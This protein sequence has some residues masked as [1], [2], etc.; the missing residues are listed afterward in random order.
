MAFRLQ[1]AQ[2]RG[3]RGALDWSMLDLA[4]AAGLSVSTIQR[5]EKGRSE[6]ISGA[7]YSSLQTAF[8]MAGVRFLEDE[9]EGAGLRVRQS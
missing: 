1:S 6:I 7:V 2:I 3:A 5:A 9:G 4:K 8:E